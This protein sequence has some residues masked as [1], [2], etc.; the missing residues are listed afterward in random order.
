M[1]TKN[2]RLMVVL[3][4]PLYQWVK[5]SAKSEGLSLSTKL[6]DLVREAYESYEDRYWAREGEKRA[7][8]FKYSQAISHEEF[9]KK[10][11]L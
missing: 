5:K 4:P 1:A 6:R 3:E 11:G 8:T 9:W 10:A 2:P 7:K